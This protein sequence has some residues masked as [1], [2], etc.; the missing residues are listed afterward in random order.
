M[1]DAER[2]ALGAAQERL[3][4]ALVGGADPP[5]GFDPERIRVQARALRAK[6]AHAHAQAHPPP[7]T[8]LFALRALR[9][10]RAGA[11]PAGGTDGLP[12]DDAE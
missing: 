4:A 5:P 10:R 9:G 1:S 6:H 12:G 3:L 8:R 7:R 2:A 11:R